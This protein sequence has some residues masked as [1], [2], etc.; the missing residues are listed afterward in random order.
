[1][2]RKRSFDPLVGRAKTLAFSK[3]LLAIYD[4]K[5]CVGHLLRRSTGAYEAFDIRDNSVGV[6]PDLIS[7]ANAVSAASSPR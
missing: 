1:M 7:A 6:Y 2:P 4:D 5:T 3:S